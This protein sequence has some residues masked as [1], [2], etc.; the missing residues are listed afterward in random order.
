[1]QPAR[2]PD[3]SVG[4]GEEFF[5]GRLADVAGVQGVVEMVL[6]FHQ[7]SPREFQIS[8]KVR[9]PKPAEALGDRP[10]RATCGAADLFAE[11]EIMRGRR[12]GHECIDPLFQF[13]RQLPALELSIVSCDHAEWLST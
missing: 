7:R 5:V 2:R 1:M 8:G 4:E 3:G 6:G 12:R 10:R 13:V 11:F 9:G